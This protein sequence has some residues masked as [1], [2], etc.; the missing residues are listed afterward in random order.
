MR[1]A[2]RHPK[3]YAANKFSHPTFPLSAPKVGLFQYNPIAKGMQANH[4]DGY[5]KNKKPRNP[6]FGFFWSKRGESNS[7]L[8]HGKQSFYH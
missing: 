4:F 1:R 3:H 6:R 5:K 2:L 7:H 8:L